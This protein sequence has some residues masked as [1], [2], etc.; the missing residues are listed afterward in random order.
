VPGSWRDPDCL[1]KPEGSQVNSAPSAP[2]SQLRL[3]QPEPW[4][5]HWQNPQDMLAELWGDNQPLVRSLRNIHM[6]CAEAGHVVTACLLENWIDETERR[7][8]PLCE[9]FRT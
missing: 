8:W 9:T 3:A 6:L 1:G 2:A 7:V 4:R 5:E